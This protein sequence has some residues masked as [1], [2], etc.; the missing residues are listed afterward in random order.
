VQT[1]ALKRDS[2]Y[3]GNNQADDI[4]FSFALTLFSLYLLV[5]VYATQDSNTLLVASIAAFKR[6]LN[7]IC[8][9]S[10]GFLNPWV[11]FHA[12]FVRLFLDEPTCV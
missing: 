1:Y 4:V 3:L 2:E 11:H 10:C 7:L 5:S 6:A 12:V 8:Q 9:P